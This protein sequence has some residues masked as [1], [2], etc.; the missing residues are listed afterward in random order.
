LLVPAHRWLYGSID[1]AVNH[2]RRY[3]KATLDELLHRHGFV[4]EVLRY[5]NP[6]GA[7]G[8]Y[9]SSRLMGATTLPRGPLRVYDRL[10]PILRGLDR[11][12]LGFGLS[13]WAVGRR[14]T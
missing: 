11:V 13:L 3:D 12:P 4:A 14:P 1:H 5:V 10:V 8:W 7:I 9:T 6:L 2:E